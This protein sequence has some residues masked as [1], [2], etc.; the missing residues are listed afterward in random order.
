M[1]LSF[2]FRTVNISVKYHHVNVDIDDQVAHTEIDQVFINDSDINNLEAIYIFPLPKGVALD[3]F[4]M[5]VDDQELVAEVLDADSAAAYYESIVRKN[6]DPALL[7]YMGQGLFRA[8]IFP[9]NAFEEKRIKMSYTEVI[10]YDSDIYR[11]LYPLNTEKFSA[12]PL[13]EVLV[14]VNLTSS[15]PIKTIYSPSHPIVVQKQGDYH[16]TITYS[17]Q[18]VKP[19]IDFVL[20]FAVSTDDIGLHLLSHNLPDEDGF[21][22]FMA[23]PKIEISESEVVRKRLLFVLDRSGSMSGQK[24]DQAKEALRF[25]VNS[26]NQNDFFN[27]VDFSSTI[28]QFKFEPVAANETNIGEALHYIDRFIANGGTNI[29]EALLT[30][31]Q[32]MAHD[33]LANMIIFLTD[34]QPTVGVTENQQIRQNVNSANTVGARLFTFG[35]GYD[36][37]STLLDN[38]TQDNHGVFYLCS[39]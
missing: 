5:F 8:R 16:A 17:E 33:E 10:E 18:Q 22:M 6:I 2:Q 9:F 12:R 1:D 31:L 13:E 28:N 39:A 26:L 36:V 15:N 37:N 7:E 4:S 32:Q 19:N 34:G 21:Y 38:L 29:N 30:A 25:C 11:Y 27:I 3:H 23:A 35:V 14:N 20:Y 24:I